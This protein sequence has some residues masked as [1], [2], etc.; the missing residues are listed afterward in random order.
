M[1]HFASQMSDLEQKL[2]QLDHLAAVTAEQA[3]FLRLL[4]GIH[5]SMFMAAERVFTPG[6]SE[7]T[8]P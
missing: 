2:T 4:G 1:A 6:D 5:A 7:E 8:T 3:S